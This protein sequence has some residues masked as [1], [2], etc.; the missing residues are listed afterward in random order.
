M[1][2]LASGLETWVDIGEESQYPIKYAPYC[3]CLLVLLR[4]A[5]RSDASWVGDRWVGSCAYSNGECGAKVIFVRRQQD[6]KEEM[7]I[8]MSGGWGV[9][10]CDLKGVSY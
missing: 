2:V 6:G 7:K 10:E 4:E 1:V 5:M 8:E 9:A 3:S